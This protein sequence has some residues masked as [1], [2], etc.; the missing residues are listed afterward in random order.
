MTAVSTGLTVGELL[1]RV[2]GEVPDRVAL[3]AGDPDPERRRRW[4]YR[5]LLDAAGLSVCALATSLT[6]DARDAGEWQRSRESIV[7]AAGLARAFGAP[8]VRV[9][10][11]HAQ[12]GESVNQALVRIARR[13][14]ELAIDCCN[15]DQPAPVRILLQNGGS[16]VRPKEL[17]SLLEVA[18]C[19]EAGLCWRQLAI[20]AKALAEGRDMTEIG[21]M[22]DI[23]LRTI[24]VLRDA[25][26]I[27]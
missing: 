27:E 6:L 19:S 24:A 7:D 13:L 9:L 2:A 21:L 11:Q 5:E 1:R 17:W 20:V 8:A 26:R 12:R 14:R 18:N 3:V 25:G 15:S 16:F 10:G 23:A 22:R 4:S